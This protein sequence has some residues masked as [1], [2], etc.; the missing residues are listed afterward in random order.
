M[1]RSVAVLRQGNVKKV[2]AFIEERAGSYGPAF[3]ILK[4][5]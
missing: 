2:V 1:Q 3:F 4:L 5:W